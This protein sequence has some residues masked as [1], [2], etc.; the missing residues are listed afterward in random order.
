MNNFD[1][2]KLAVEMLSGGTNTVI[3]DDIGMPSIMVAVPKLT[4]AELIT[5][6]AEN[7]HPGFLVD[8]SEQTVAYMSKYQNIVQNSRAYSLP[9]QDPRANITFDQSLEACR[10]KG[11]GWGVQPASLWSAI[12]L[13]CKKNG[14]QPHGNNNFGRDVASTWEKGVV[15]YTYEDSGTKNGRTAT[16]SGP[17][18]W[19]HDG[20]YAGIADMNG[21]VW[22]WCAGIRLVNGQVQFIIN[23]DSI[24]ATCDMGASSAQWKALDKDG[25]FVAPG[26]ANTL[27]LD[28]VSNKWKWVTGE[29]SSAVDQSR[30]CAFKDITADEGVDANAQAI[31][32]L[33]TLMPEA[34][35]EYSGDYFWANNAQAERFLYR[36]GDWS[37]GAGAGVFNSNFNYPRSSSAHTVGFRSAFYGKL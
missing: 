12:A 10:K 25:N 9:M 26:S 17:A 5:G 28:Y 27:K 24:L 37:N 23:A 15:T 14:F 7:A 18:T 22:E 29:L 32:Q 19:Y 16:G 30:S 31:L 21:N 35:G 8:G 6:G 33:M 3:F 20:T 1:D 4:R 34:E 2:L 13:W 36:G 11:E